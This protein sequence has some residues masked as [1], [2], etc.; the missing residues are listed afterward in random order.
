MDRL[1]VGTEVALR[2]L[3]VEQAVDAALAAQARLLEAL[4]EGRAIVRLSAPAADPVLTEAIAALDAL[5]AGRDRVVRCHAALADLQARL[6]F[7]PVD[8]GQGDK[9]APER[10]HRPRSSAHADAG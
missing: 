9:A 4:V 1:S 3:A 7:V 6:G 10:P 5:A 8:V 2:L